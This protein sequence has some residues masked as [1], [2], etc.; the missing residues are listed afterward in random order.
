[1]NQ[2]PRRR[3]FLQS[4][5]CLC[6]ALL[7]PALL[8]GTPARGA[9]PPAGPSRGEVLQVLS[10]ARDQRPSAAA[11]RPVTVVLLADRKDHGAGE[12][13]YPRWQARW[14]L[15][16]GGSAA[17]PEQAAN[18]AGPDLPDPGVTRGLP[19][20]RV[21]TAQSWPTVTQ[22]ETADVIVAFCYLPW[23]AER[24]E[25]VRRYVAR[26]GGLVLIH[27]A[28]WTR[29]KASPDVAAVC[30]V[31]GFERWRHG[32]LTLEITNPKHPICL[33]PPPPVRGEDEP[34]WPP[35]PPID[36]QRV[37]VLAASREQT[38]PDREGVALQPQF[39]TYELGKG[40]VF[41]CV[42]GHYSW[43]FDHPYFRLLLLR[44]MAWAAHESP[45]RFD[46]A[47]LR[48]AAVTP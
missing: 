24:I 1:M 5:V 26:G 22:W 30:G 2:T 19:G 47:I 38:K 36:P 20:V 41:G 44:G 6:C 13:D 23:N 8:A 48:S 12:H 14:A 10:A 35:T 37:Q 42:P 7:W 46:E 34:Y 27:S 25:Q 28:T 16:L 31:G 4:A 11:A 45:F 18:L 9:A 32:A 39:W 17:S 3:R 40:R 15:L 33:P 21:Q 43:T 29:P